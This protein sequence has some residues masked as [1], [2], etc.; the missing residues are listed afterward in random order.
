MDAR[1]AQSAFAPGRGG[2]GRRCRTSAPASKRLIHATC[3]TGPLW[4]PGTRHFEIMTGAVGAP[5]ARACEA[6]KGGGSRWW[7]SAALDCPSHPSIRPPDAGGERDSLL[8]TPR[9]SYT[10]MEPSLSPAAS[11]LGRSREKAT[12]VTPAPRGVD[13]RATGAEGFRTLHTAMHPA[14]Q[15]K[16]KEIEGWAWVCEGAALSS[17]RRSP[18]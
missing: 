7:H 14:L 15:R 12:A 18:C 6:C 16:R 1:E 10:Q 5:L 4:A 2:V 11:M 3:R 17:T 9:V 8:R 13:K